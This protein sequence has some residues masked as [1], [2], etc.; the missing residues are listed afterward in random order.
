MNA[1]GNQIAVFAGALVCTGV[2]SAAASQV[3]L[4]AILDD[5]NQR[6]PEDE[7]ESYFAPWYFGKITR[8]IS[9]YER[10]Y[11]TGRKV[12]WLKVAF[13]A[14]VTAIVFWAFLATWYSAFH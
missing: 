12:F 4:Y 2:I 5:V 6:R 14:A 13:V 7:Q 9:H 1:G 10:E 8:V 3:L 11:P